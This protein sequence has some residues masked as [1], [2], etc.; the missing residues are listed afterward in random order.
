MISSDEVSKL[1]N[2]ARLELNDGELDSLAKDLEAILGYVSELNSAGV[3]TGEVAEL[4]QNLPKNITRPDQS[5]APLP[6]SA[7]ALIAAAPRRAGKLV[8]VKK[9]L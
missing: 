7:E 6:E 3:K 8:A 2:L 4:D 5:V 9:I 1:A